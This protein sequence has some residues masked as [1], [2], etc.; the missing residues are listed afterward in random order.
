MGY[1]PWACRVRHNWVTNTFSA[2]IF[3]WPFL[4]CLDLCIVSSHKNTSHM[5]IK[6][7]TNPLWLP[8]NLITS[9]SPY[10][11]VG[12]H[13]EVLSGQK[14]GEFTF[15]SPPNSYLSH[16]QNA[17]SPSQ[18][19]QKSKLIPASTL[20]PK[21]HLNINS[22]YSKSHYPNDL[23]QVSLSNFIWISQKNYY[24]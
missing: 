9:V 5:E 6:T 8:L 12:S 13:S 19:L 3:M 21:S 7:H 11:Q 10:F 2:Y 16:M 1:S 14:F 20:I 24:C 23:N 15:C 4:L 17:F 22:K 18:H